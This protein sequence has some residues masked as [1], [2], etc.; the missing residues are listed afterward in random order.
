MKACRE[1][2]ERP[3]VYFK[4]SALDEACPLR[5]RL[6]GGEHIPTTTTTIGSLGPLQTYS[7]PT[8]ASSACGD[9]WAG[10]TYSDI[11]D[12]LCRVA[13]YLQAH[14]IL[15][16]QP[17][18]AADPV[19]VAVYCTKSPVW[20]SAALATFV[21]GGT[22]VPID[23]NLSSA[24]A[25]AAAAALHC[26]A[27]LT[28][29]P[30]ALQQA[31]GTHNSAL[32]VLSIANALATEPGM[33]TS[34]AAGGDHV[35]T[36]SVACVALTSGTST[37]RPKGVLLSHHNL[38]SNIASV[39]HAF[40]HDPDADRVFSV[41]PLH[42]MFEL[43]AGVL[44]PFAAGVSVVQS[45]TFNPAQ[46]LGNMQAS[47]PTY[48]VGVPRLLEV[49]HQRIDDRLN[50]LSPRPYRWLVRAL[51]AAN[52]WSDRRLGLNL[53]RLVFRPL[54]AQ[55]GGSLKFFVSGGSALAPCEFNFFAAAGLPVLEGY[56]A[57]ETS[58]IVAMST[59]ASRRAGSV[60]RAIDGVQLRI[61]AAAVDGTNDEPCAQGERVVLGTDEV[62]EVQVRG[63][64]VMLG[65]D[66]NAEATAEV[67]D[68]GGWYHT[69]D[70]GRLDSDGFL[71]I[72]GRMGDMVLT[73]NGENVYVASGGVVGCTAA[74]RD[75]TTA[76]HAAIL[77]MCKR[78][79]VTTW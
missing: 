42:H 35:D 49:L 4:P 72:M 30:T 40:Q 32:Q 33:A 19:R 45:P 2:A 51:L 77:M 53:G 54:H 57:S 38:T 37:G 66:R 8:D 78:T 67:L 26:A 55:F 17:S 5:Y 24:K 70:L 75:L 63:P 9:D 16:A 6:A 68:E 31:L 46:L 3:F 61:V 60:G 52:A 34:E 41:L 64:N 13:A 65:Y 44:A 71:Y 76:A 29:A 15:S 12:D 50:Q 69:G 39:C 21:V 59:P 47:Q 36:S 79:L 7:S 73:A 14:N 23:R 10:L 27:V 48:I 62:G 1:H 58:P 18:A 28:D 11:H 20:L 56:G 25:A 74:C 22:L 43:T